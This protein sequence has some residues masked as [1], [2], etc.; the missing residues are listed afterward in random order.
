MKRYLKL[1]VMVLLCTLLVVGCGGKNDTSSEFDDILTE[2]EKQENKLTTSDNYYN[3]KDY[4]II[5]DNINGYLSSVYYDFDKDSEKEFLIARVKDSNLVLSLYDY[6]DEVLKEYDSFVL[7]EGMMDYSD[8][9]T[10]NCFIKKIDGE[11][12]IYLES[13]GYSNLVADGISWNFRKV[14]F[15]NGKF[16]DVAKESFNGSYLEEE[17]LNKKKEYVKDTSLSIIKFAFEENGQTLYEQNKSNSLNFFT[18][19]RKHLE[20]FDQSKYYDTNET[21]VKYGVTN[22]TTDV[23]SDYNLETYI[24]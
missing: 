17:Y 2:L 7:L 11:L 1:F 21:K 3:P 13:V 19:E 24:K 4:E 8:E 14:G 5:K 16:W 9:L 6:K 20:D 22:Y 15:S 12:F 23:A 18:I 10:I